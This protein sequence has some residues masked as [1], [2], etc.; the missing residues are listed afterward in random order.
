[1]GLSNLLAVGRSMVGFG[2]KPAYRAAEPGLVPKFEPS[3]TGNTSDTG[4]FASAK[5][6]TPTD[7]AKAT[8]PLSSTKTAATLTFAKTVSKP[9]R[10]L[11]GWLLGGNRRRTNERL[12]QGEFRL[13]NVRPLQNSLRDDDSLTV[14]ERRDPKLLFQTPPAAPTKDDQDH[15]WSRLRGRNQASLVVKPD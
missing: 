6:S 4:L 8:N 13:Q 12:V 5:V 3:V 15:A 14:V 2:R 11:F 1:M 7:P 9:K 10:S